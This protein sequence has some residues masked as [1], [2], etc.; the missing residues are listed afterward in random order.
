MK[1]RWA[2][3]A[4]FVLSGVAEP[5]QLSYRDVTVQLVSV[6]Q[7]QEK[8]LTALRSDLIDARKDITELQQAFQ[9]L[10]DRQEK[11]IETEK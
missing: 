7:A 9:E 11:K 4:L 8:E 2:I 10:Y 3:L 6:L 5:K 1:R